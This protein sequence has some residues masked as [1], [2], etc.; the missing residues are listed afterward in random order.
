MQELNTFFVRAKNRIAKKNIVFAFKMVQ[1]VISFAFV[2]SV[3]INNTMK[4]MKAN[5]KKKEDGK[6]MQLIMSLMKTSL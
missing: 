3:K 1:N 4:M 6:D 5:Q 2:K